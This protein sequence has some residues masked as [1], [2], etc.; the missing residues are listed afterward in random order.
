M[1]ATGWLFGIL[2]VKR[3]TGHCKQNRVLDT[4]FYGSTH[5][6]LDR[7]SRCRKYRV[8]VER[9]NMSVLRQHDDD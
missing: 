5:L 8:S 6:E 7:R 9:E 2:L 4:S 1:I 3:A